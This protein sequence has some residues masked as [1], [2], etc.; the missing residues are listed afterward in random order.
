VRTDCLF[1]GRTLHKNS[2]CKAAFYFE[3]S[4]HTARGFIDEECFITFLTAAIYNIDKKISTDDPAWLLFQDSA[5]ESAFV[6]RGVDIGND[7]EVEVHRFDFAGAHLGRKLYPF[8]ES[9]G[10]VLNREKN[11]LYTLLAETLMGFGGKLREAFLLVHPVNPADPESIL[12]ED[13]YRG[14]E[15]LKKQIAERL[16]ADG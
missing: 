7:Q 4:D 11:R 16:K 10:G 13:N 3:S 8:K 14:I 1:C 12:R 2:D 15:R 5:R 9:N 6:F